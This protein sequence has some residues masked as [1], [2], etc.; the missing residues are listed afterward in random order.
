[1]SDNNSTTPS[2]HN[3]PSTDDEEI[4]IYSTHQRGSARREIALRRDDQTF[5][6]MQE[7]AKA[8]LLYG[9]IASGLSAGLHY[10]LLPG[11]RIYATVPP[12]YRLLLVVFLIGV[13][14]IGSFRDG[15]FLHKD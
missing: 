8:A 5:E 11:A 4:T 13:N 12:V 1:M 2:K 15:C 10:K 7:G 9:G 6:V 3:T 14:P